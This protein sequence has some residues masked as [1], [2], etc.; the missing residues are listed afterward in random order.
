MGITPG[1][2]HALPTHDLPFPMW[3]ILLVTTSYWGL[4]LGGVYLLIAW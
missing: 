3:V 4:L 2:N 1:H